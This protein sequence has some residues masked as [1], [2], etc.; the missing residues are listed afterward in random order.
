MQRPVAEAATRRPG[1]TSKTQLKLFNAAMEIMGQRGPEFATVEEVAQLA[2][3][4]KGT[5]YYN[6]GSKKTMID[7]LLQYGTDLL[8]RQMEAAAQ[9]HS[10]PREALRVSIYTALKYLEDRPGYARLWIAEV[11]KSMNDWSESM[12]DSRQS[13]LDFIEARVA[14]LSKRY[15]IDR[16][17]DVRSTSVAIFGAAYMLSMDRVIHSSPRTAEDA[18]RAVMQVVDGYIRR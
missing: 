14:A 12:V 18:T 8:L 9:M 5:V 1:R 3:V 11:W 4:S 15:M 13:L 16:A 17:Q 6:F 10:D 2:G 7:Q